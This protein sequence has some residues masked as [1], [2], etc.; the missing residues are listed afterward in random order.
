MSPRAGGEADKLGNRYEGSWTVRQL[1]NVLG[2]RAKSITVEEIG[3]AGD[4]IEFALERNTGVVEG[5]QVK[6]QHGNANSWTIRALGDEGVLQSAARQ[7][8]DGRQ[9]HFVSTVHSRSL[10]ELTLRARSSERAT[11]EKSLSKKLKAEFEK[12]KIELG[13]EHDAYDVLQG[14]YVRPQEEKEI[15]ATNE[16]LSE[17]LVAGA[18]GPAVAAVLGDLIL[19]NLGRP[20]DAARI[21]EKLR[22]YELEP[23]HLLG[24]AQVTTAVGDVYDAW[25]ATIDRELLQPVIPRSEA[26]EILEAIKSKDRRVVLAAGTAG[27]GKSA[28][29][30]QVLDGLDEGWS[31]LGMRLDRIEPFSSPYELGTARLGLPSSPVAS[32]AA[33]ADGGD[34]LLVIDQLDAVSRTSGRMPLTFDAVA[35]LLR[36]A[37]AF[38]NIRILIACR[39]F[40]IDNDDRLRRLVQDGERVHTV[41]IGPLSAEQ[42]AAAVTGMGV[43]AGTLTDEQRELLRSPLHLV[44]LSA[45]SDEDGALAFGS[46]EDLLDA[47]WRRKLQDARQRRP[48]RYSTTVNTLVDYMSDHQRLA[49]PEAVLDDDDLTAE[50]EVLASEQ[51]I[52]RDGRQLSFFHEA[53]F[54]YAFARAW[55]T[56]KQTLT[57]FLQE[58]EQELFR[59]AQVRQVLTHLRGQ[60]PPRFITEVEALLTDSGIRFHIKEVVLALLRALPDPTS[61]ELAL[62]QRLIAADVPFAG[63]LWAGLS[64]PAWAR[65]LDHEDQLRQWLASDDEALQ[66]HALEI[67]TFGL[68]ADR[69]GQLIAPH[70]DRAD[71]GQWLNVVVGHG[72]VYDSRVL[73]DLMLAAVRNGQMGPG[74]H[75][76][77]MAYYH[78]GECQPTW[79]IELIHT[80]LAERPDAL[81]LDTI[82]GVAQLEEEDYGLSKV[83]DDAATREP[84][85]FATTMVPY[86]LDAMAATSGTGDR[87]T[88]NHQWDLRFFNQESHDVGDV[89]L[90][91]TAEALRTL[92]KTED[93]ALEAVLDQL[94]ADD[95]SA[96][97]WLLYQALIAAGPARADQSAAIL[98]EGEHRLRSG[99]S[100]QAH[101]TTRELLAA[102]S[103][104]VDAPTFLALE[105]LCLGYHP[106]RASRHR[107]AEFTVLSGLDE[108]RLSPE[109]LRRLG[110]LREYYTAE[111]PE[112]PQGASSGTIGSPIPAHEAARMSDEDWLRAIA[113]H[114]GPA[115]DY[116][117]GTGGAEELAQQLEAQTKDDPNRFARLCLRLGD[118]TN[119]HYMNGI[120]MGLADKEGAGDPALVYAAVRHAATLDSSDHDR[121]IPWAIR[122]LVTDDVP[123]DVIRIVLDIALR[124]PDPDRDRWLEITSIG[125]AYYNGDPSFD[126][127]NTARGEACLRLGELL[128][129]DADGH[130]TALVVDSLDMLASDPVLSV[131]ACAAHT[132][133][134]GLKHA[135]ER[136][137]TA[138][139]RL[140]DTSDERV[141]AVRPVERLTLYIGATHPDVVMPVIARMLRSAHER[142]REAGG[143]LAAYA[144]T[145][146]GNA[147][148]LAGAAEGDAAAR[149]GAARACAARLP[150]A[151]N[152][153]PADAALRRFFNDPEATVRAA[154]AELAGSLRGEKLG[155]HEDILDALLDSAAFTDAAPQLLITLERATD[156]VDRLIRRT[157]ERYL[158]ARRDGVDSMGSDA[159][160]AREL[161][162]LLLRSYAQA[163][164]ARSRSQILDLVDG[165]LERGSYR[166]ADAV[167]Q[168]ER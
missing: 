147:D 154:A 76:L 119:P 136:A 96:A 7:I 11:F 111:Q 49:A 128:V 23:A 150:F 65:R 104:A 109:G 89:L 112:P 37:T 73:F 105:A 100:D 83:I 9:F 116:D 34:A 20:L 134:G 55:M 40:D 1:L 137:I 123:D 146:Y 70:A 42:V 57:T 41:D 84:A 164:D 127:M 141:L 35:D 48:G 163:T 26:N 71:F 132:I 160:H 114:D 103:P 108:A 51:V 97:Q 77:W 44:L 120:L 43:D 107:Y 58:G 151:T 24:A 64:T 46:S 18:R 152:P 91:A 75:G 94:A 66:R 124:S 149:R 86:M 99:Y 67:L 93:P 121:W 39:R 131:R 59:R 25:R 78:L 81:A 56:K 68:G 143:R 16:V 2:G 52:V 115:R 90:T 54:D 145:E 30:S 72:D 19:E 138:Y 135:R 165:Y 101:W 153:A 82:G 12:L 33:A 80:W 8:A 50:A 122:H 4:G 118:D 167:G 63:R 62:V 139:A 102:I 110:Q 125:D 161:G 142:A 31:V 98:L 17:V 162:D 92:A 28:V 88:W 106:E 27:A 38:P 85:M 155:P 144:A 79:A 113:E 53:F 95:H 74:E 126:G 15:R 133:S 157:A 5:H 156:K 158:D 13:P 159:L 21:R 36:E 60:E 10:D 6:R 69:R 130:R 168:A 45:I 129:A 47:F 3:E 87:P 166:F 148:L 32:L 140:A 14:L 22:D 29:M 117:K 61:D